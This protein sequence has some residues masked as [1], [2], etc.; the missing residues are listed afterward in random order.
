MQL[1][2]VRKLNQSQCQQIINLRRLVWE[3]EKVEFLDNSIMT[4]TTFFDALGFQNV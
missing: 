1:F 2:I 4:N 3:H